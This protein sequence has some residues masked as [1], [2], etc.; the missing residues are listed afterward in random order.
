MALSQ[1][2]LPSVDL[3]QVRWRGFKHH[4]QRLES[5]RV[6]RLENVNKLDYVT[7]LGELAQ[8]KD[9]SEHAFGISYIRK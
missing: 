7:M 6:I 2:K 4:V 3:P 8:D 1:V 5:L 9:L